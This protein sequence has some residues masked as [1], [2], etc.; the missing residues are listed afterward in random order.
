[1]SHKDEI[2]EF[3]NENW[4]QVKA[5][6]AELVAVESVEDLASAAPG[7]PFG[8]GS[9]AALDT[10]L[11][12][13]QRLGLATQDVEGYIGF[14]EVPG[15]GDEVLATIAHADVVPDGDGWTGDPRTLREREGYL[16]GRGVIDD[17]GPLV[18]TLWVAKYL[19]DKAEAEGKAPKRTFRALIGTNEETSMGDVPHYLEA[20][21]QPWFLF[22]PDAEFP[23][24]FGEK[25]VFHTH[26]TTGAIA[27]APLLELEGGTVINAV[28]GRAHAVLAL[29]PEDLPAA[30]GITITA[31]GDGRTLVEAT[32]KGGHASIPEGTVNAI[33][34]LARYL[35][36]NG[37]H[38]ENQSVFLDF[39][40]SLTEKTDG[41]TMG[42]ASHDDIFGSLTM[43]AGTIHTADGRFT[44]S[45]DI[46][47]P[48]SITG[49]HIEAELFKEA[50]LHGCIMEKP[51]IKEPFYVDPETP[52]VKIM[53]D[54]YNDHTGADAEPFTIGGGTYARLF[55][56]ASSFGPEERTGK[57]PEWVG[58]MH[59]PDEGVS[60]QLLKDALAIYIDA[61]EQLLEL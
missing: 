37:L 29:D 3:V 10:T 26:F 30:P 22:T 45:L 43:V 46:R 18:L 41:S 31:Q 33:G 1:M 59:G 25:G 53:I 58:P 49:A 8:D 2:R 55:E 6:I 39:L 56:R 54:T 48:T 61:A 14:A 36:D 52:E 15:E 32:G 13:A 12:I 16:I 40:I 7:K 60:E 11:A 34:L 4:D 50:E 38:N 51:E 5:D 19:K 9:R 57:E 21:G 20:Y 17:K 27:G 35:K 42:I 47:Y 44:Q 24:C 23:V 28:P